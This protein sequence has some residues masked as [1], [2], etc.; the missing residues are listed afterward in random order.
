MQKIIVY[1]C[2]LSDELIWISLQVES[3]QQ[4]IFTSWKPWKSKVYKLKAC[5]ESAPFAV[6]L[7]KFN[8]KPFPVDN[9]VDVD[10]GDDDDQGSNM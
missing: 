8:H 10:V 3:L 6:Q 5:D 1:M 9:N 4:E 7:S 2:K